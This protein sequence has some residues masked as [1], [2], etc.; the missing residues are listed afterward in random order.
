MPSVRRHNWYL[1]SAVDNSGDTEVMKTAV[2]LLDD[3][4][5]MAEGVARRLKAFRIQLNTSAGV[6]ERLNAVY[7]RRSVKVDPA[8]TRA[9]LRPI[10]NE[11]W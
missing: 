6:T 1:P 5:R 8:L 4:F 9:Q 2:S 11:R 7:A 10:D 3:L